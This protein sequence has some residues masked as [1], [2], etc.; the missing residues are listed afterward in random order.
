VDEVAPEVDLM[1]QARYFKQVY[2]GLLTRMALLAL[3][4]GAL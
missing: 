1:P 3:V 2:Y 4:L